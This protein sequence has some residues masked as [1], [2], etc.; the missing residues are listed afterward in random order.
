MNKRQKL[1]H[2]FFL[3][4]IGAA[5][6][7]LV[8]LFLLMMV[9][10]RG[11]AMGRETFRDV[12]AVNDLYLQGFLV[13]PVLCL[14]YGALAPWLYPTKPFVLR[15]LQTLLLL[16]VAAWILTDYVFF[17]FCSVP[18]P[19]NVEG[20][21]GSARLSSYYWNNMRLNYM[22]IALTA[23]FLHIAWLYFPRPCKGRKG[24]WSYCVLSVTM[25]VCGVL[26]FVY[27]FCTRLGPFFWIGAFLPLG[28]ALYVLYTSILR[29]FWWKNSPLLKALA[30]VSVVLA[31][32]LSFSPLALLSFPLWR[33]FGWFKEGILT[34]LCMAYL[35]SFFAYWAL[36]IW[37]RSLES[38]WPKQAQ[39]GEPVGGKIPEADA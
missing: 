31:S 23:S 24:D 12:W 13:M 15:I 25:I 17:D 19:E 35:G 39:E 5:W 3:G 26:P 20:M 21:D 28:L 22:I 37:Q 33:H 2:G 1:F 10:G 29:V 8:V 14:V 27:A 11:E 30:V 4:V 7:T 38:T 6:L 32:L 9:S 16:A 18:R 34:L 36:G